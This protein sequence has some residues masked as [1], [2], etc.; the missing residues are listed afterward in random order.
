MNAITHQNLENLIAKKVTL[1]QPQIEQGATS[2]NRIREL[3]SNKKETDP[4]FPW[5]IEGDFLSGSYARGTK[6]YPLNDIDVMM[7]LDGTGL[8]LLQNGYAANVIVRGSG[9]RGSPILS[10]TDERGYI[11]S[12]M[13]LDA[14][15]TALS[16]AYPN[17]KISKDGQ[18]VNVWFDT[19]GLGLDIVPCVHILPQDGSK[20]RYYIPEGGE[21]TLWIPT[22]PK[23]DKEI[24]D[25]VD[26]L[27]GKKLKPVIKLIK[28]WNATQ[29]QERLRSYH[30]EVLAWQVFYNGF[31]N[32]FVISDYPS[33]IRYFFQNVAPHLTAICPDPTTIGGNIDRY[34][35]QATRTLSLLKIG[36]ARTALAPTAF[37]GLLGSGQPSSTWHKVFPDLKQ[38]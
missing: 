31:K 21:S 2:H 25:Y 30:L 28:Y 33:A 7:V 24:G 19:Y 5:L 4:S 29:N 23:H 20:E 9:E 32:N 8:F 16:D 1:S 10:L 22:N 37:A 6:I 26:N 38:I 14:F 15:R 27:H 18:A 13:V 17:S 35:G 36:E 34:L 12:K 11:S 3:L